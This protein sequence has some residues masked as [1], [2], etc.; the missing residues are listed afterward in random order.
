MRRT[1]GATK[2]HP[3]PSGAVQ[4]LAL[5]GSVFPFTATKSTGLAERTTQR[6]E[7]AQLTSHDFP[8]PLKVLDA[9]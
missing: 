2:N 9:E 6:A 8:V 4:L 3:E 1:A 5:V 7:E